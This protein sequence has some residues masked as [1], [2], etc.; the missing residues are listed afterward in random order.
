MIRTNYFAAISMALFFTIPAFAENS[1]TENSQLLVASL[2]KA[3]APENVKA[4]AMQQKTRYCE[5]NAKNKKLQGSNK[6]DYLIACL[7]KNE[8]I[9][10]FSTVYNQRMASSDINEML[11]QSPTAAGKE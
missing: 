1:A 3:S 10:A 7:N 2:A 6:E 11:K 4:I 8:A 5:Q 9:L